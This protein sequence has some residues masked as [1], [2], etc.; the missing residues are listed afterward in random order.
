MQKFVE[1]H[2]GT[3]RDLDTLLAW[4][5]SVTGTVWRNW[6]DVRK[7][8]PHADPYPGDLICFNVGGNKYRILA[9]IEYIPDRPAV[10]YVKAVLTHK[11]YDALNKQK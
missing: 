4:C 10:V 5:N 1:S 9:G 3:E 6:S 8:F 7:S 11:E 2:P